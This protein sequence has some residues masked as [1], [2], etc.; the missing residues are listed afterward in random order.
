MKRFFV[1]ILALC[2]LILA[3]CGQDVRDKVFSRSGFSITLPQ[4][5]KDT[6]F[7]DEAIEI[8]YLFMADD[9]IITAM[10]INKAD[11][12]DLSL[13]EFGELLIS[14]NGFDAA[15]EQKD[16]LFTYTYHD[17]GDTMVNIVLETDARFWFV[18][19]TCDEEDYAKLKPTMWKYLQSVTVC[20]D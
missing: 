7:S 18:S 6:S 8:P 14:A 1:L 3:G 10:E 13:A 11:F 12:P 16:G 2:L 19:A 20:D 4:N 15:L 5:A 17:E 9:V